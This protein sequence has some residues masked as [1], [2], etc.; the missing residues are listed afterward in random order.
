MISIFPTRKKGASPFLTLKKVTH[1]GSADAGSLLQ[2]GHHGEASSGAH[3][4]E[5]VN[6]AVGT[7]V[8]A[9][10]AI[11]G[12]VVTSVGSKGVNTDS[13]GISSDLQGTAPLSSVPG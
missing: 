3:V 9:V 6:T 2:I 7:N 1:V 12:D 11:F 10:D 13:E 5:I 8:A 4:L